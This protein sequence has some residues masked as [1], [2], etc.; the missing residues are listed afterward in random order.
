MGLLLSAELVMVGAA[1]IG[2]SMGWLGS[3][4]GVVMLERIPESMRGRIMGTQN[5]ILTAAAPLGIVTAALFIHYVDVDTAGAV[6]AVTWVLAA[7]VAVLVPALRN[8]DPDSIED[9]AGGRHEK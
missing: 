5:A 9:Q 3:L 4:M 6:L 1:V 7:V 8:L 2:L